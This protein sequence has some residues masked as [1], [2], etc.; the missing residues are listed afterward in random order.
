MKYLAFELI[1]SDDGSLDSTLYPTAAE[2]WQELFNQFDTRISD[3]WDDENGDY[4]DLIIRRLTDDQKDLV[5][6]ALMES[7]IDAKIEAGVIDMTGFEVVK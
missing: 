4:G 7:G 3:W 6:E 1:V 5:L 2:A